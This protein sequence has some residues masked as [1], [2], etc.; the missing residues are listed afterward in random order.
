MVGDA[1]RREPETFERVVGRLAAVVRTE[2]PALAGDDHLEAGERPHEFDGERGLVAVGVRVDDAGALG[3]ARERRTDDGVGLLRRHHDVGVGESRL[4]GVTG[5]CRGDAGDLY[6]H[7]DIAP[8][9]RR[10][11]GGD[12]GAARGDG[13]VNCGGVV[14]PLGSAV[15]A[16]TERPGRPVA[17]EVSDAGDPRAVDSRRRVDQSPSERTGADG[18]DA[19]GDVAR[20]EPSWTVEHGC[21]ST[22]EST[23]VGTAAERRAGRPRAQSLRVAPVRHATA[24]REHSSSA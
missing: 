23:A 5:A 13:L 6:D 7:V 11:V 4:V 15:G 3:E 17:V 18:A 21:G 14:G 1:L 19:D 16:A 22:L 10:R 9:Q 2:V 20:G 24:G 12:D 8:D